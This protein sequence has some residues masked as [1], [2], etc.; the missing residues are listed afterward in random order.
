M[1]L[2][3]INKKIFEVILEGVDIIPSNFDFRANKYAIEIKIAEQI[4]DN[5]YRKDITLQIRI[6]G[7]NKNKIDMMDKADEIDVQLSNYVFEGMWISRDNAYYTT[8]IDE[9]KYN[10]V[11]QYTI[12]NY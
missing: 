2:F 12:K 5:S 8:Y 1:T 7:V 3:E 4:I 10:I 6:V 11:L 9:D